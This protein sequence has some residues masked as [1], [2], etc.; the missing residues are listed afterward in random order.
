MT[1]WVLFIPPIL[2]FNSNDLGRCP[3]LTNVL[4]KSWE[5]LLFLIFYSL[6]CV[7][8]FLFSWSV[9][10]WIRRMFNIINFFFYIM[11]AKI[12]FI[13][14]NFL[15]RKINILVS[16]NWSK[17]FVFSIVLFSYFITDNAWRILVIRSIREIGWPEFGQIRSH[18]SN[19]FLYLKRIKQ[20]QHVLISSFTGN[21]DLL[22]LIFF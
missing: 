20:L 21:L 3:T 6:N 10:D 2:C 14:D 1:F 17:S 8:V 22:L 19:A 9:R 16:L 4:W 18:A 7:Q 11:K 12:Y 13:F 5:M 15:N